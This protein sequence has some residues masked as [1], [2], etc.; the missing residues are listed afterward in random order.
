MDCQELI[1]LFNKVGGILVCDYSKNEMIVKNTNLKCNIK[2]TDYGLIEYTASSYAFSPYELNH[3]KNNMS[4]DEIKK[5]TIKYKNKYLN[6]DEI[7]F[8]IKF[9]NN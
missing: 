8:E 5:S 7:G 3:I 9:L 2:P 4:S 6:N 1:T